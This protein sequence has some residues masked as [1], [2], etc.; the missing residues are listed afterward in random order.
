M[1]PKACDR[2]YQNKEKCSFASSTEICIR[3]QYLSV[4]CHATRKKKRKGRRPILRPFD[5]G[6][7]LVWEPD[8]DGESKASNARPVA[9]TLDSHSSWTIVN[10]PQSMFQRRFQDEVLRRPFTPQ[11][12]GEAMNVVTN[13]DKFTTLHSQFA[14]GRSF[15]RDFRLAIYSALHHSAPVITDGYL[16]FLALVSHCQASCLLWAIPDLHR[17]TKA[18]RSLQ[19]TEILRSHDALCVLLL[20]Q[21]LFVFEI[22]TNSSATS[23]HS[24]VQSALISAEPWYSVLGRVPKFDTITFCPVLLDMVGCLVYRKMPIIRLCGQDR[25]VVD[26]YV[27]L[28]STLLPLLYRLCEQSHAARSNAATPSWKSMSPERPEEDYSDI[29]S[30]I[31]LWA[32]EIPPD[33]FTSYDNAE[34]RMMMIQA[35]AY[36]LATLLIIHRLRFPLGTQDDLGQFYAYRI[37]QEI[38]S[39]FAQKNTQYAGAFPVT[40]PLFIS[41]LEVEGPGED[42]LENLRSFPVQNISCENDERLRFLWPLV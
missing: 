12:A 2:C 35:K 9:H 5:H 21:A 3:C 36:R 16:A 4:T 31:E 19:S 20:G 30:S 37:I 25:I 39:F 32:P 24:I 29:Q 41:M 8:P 40:F 10:T 28:C 42:L 15:M 26:R 38:S 14:M 6:S 27:G 34:R 33:F 23:A 22:L 7:L 11:T 17:G 18:L 13:E 1:T